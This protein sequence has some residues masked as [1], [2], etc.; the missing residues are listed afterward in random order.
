LRSE[1]EREVQGI[2]NEIYK[3][4]YM[5]KELTSTV[6]NGRASQEDH[7]QSYMQLPEILPKPP[8]LI[9]L[10]QIRRRYGCIKSYKIYFVVK[11]MLPY[12]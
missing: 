1:C 5:R 3:S 12:G 11:F 2:I 6:H 10:G 7:R 8:R 4:Q 9:V